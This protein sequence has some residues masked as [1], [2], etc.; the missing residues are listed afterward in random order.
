[1][2]VEKTN[3]KH[4]IARHAYVRRLNE[5]AV[6]MRANDRRAIHRIS[7]RIL[8]THGKQW[9]AHDIMY[10]ESFRPLAATMRADL[11]RRKRQQMN[12]LKIKLDTLRQCRAE[13]LKGAVQ[14]TSCIL[15]RAEC[16]GFEE[17]WNFETFQLEKLEDLSRFA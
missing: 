11:S 10:Q 7:E 1:M 12:A 15:S 2:K 16:H 17:L 13:E 8:E 9:H 3:P 6:Q 5:Q 4:I 14:M